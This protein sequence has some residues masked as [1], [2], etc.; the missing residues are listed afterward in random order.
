MIPIAARQSI[1]CAWLP[2]A[3]SS[4]RSRDPSPA[5]C[6]I[7]NPPAP[8]F[9]LSAFCDRQVFHRSVKLPHT[10]QIGLER[11]RG[12]RAAVEKSAEPIGAGA[13]GIDP[14]V[15]ERCRFDPDI[16]QNRAGRAVNDPAWI[17]EMAETL[18][19]PAARSCQCR[20][21]VG[22][23]LLEMVGIDLG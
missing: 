18:L 14:F 21:V 8:S 4:D 15:D 16:L 12:N 5:P 3:P 17:A 20:P 2:A 7:S 19:R 9:P 22:D 6:E 10:A 1:T 23:L 13:W 11:Y